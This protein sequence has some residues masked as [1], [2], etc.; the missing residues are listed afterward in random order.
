MFSIDVNGAGM[1]A[2]SASPTSIDFGSQA[3]SASSGAHRVTVTNTGPAPLTI[4]SMSLAGTNAREFSLRNST[5][6]GTIAAGGSCAADAVFTPAVAGARVATITLQSNASNGA[7]S[8]ALR[9]SGVVV[10]APP[11]SPWASQDVGAVGVAGSVAYSGGTFTVRGSGADIWGSADAFRF[12]HQALTGDGTIVARVAAVDNVQAWTKA[13]VMIRDGAAAGAPNAAMIVSAGKGLSFQYRRTSGGITANVAAAGVAPQWVRLTRAGNIF[14]AAISSDGAAW[15]PAGQATIA[16]S[17]TVRIGLAVTSHSATQAAAGTFDHVSIAAASATSALPGGW[18]TTD[19]GASG[20]SGS[21]SEAGGTFTVAG[22]G[23]DIWGT[24]DAFRYAYGTLAAD[25]AI[26]ARVATVQSI[27]TW[28][29]AGVMIRQSLAA[30][31]A[32]ASIFVT[33]AKGIA[34]QRRAA[35]G[36]TTVSTTIAGAPPAYVKLTRAGNLVTASTSADG[37]VWKTV[38]QQTMS[39]SGAMWVGVAVS[40]HDVTQRATATFDRVTVN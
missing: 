5:C 39:F 32:H 13:G 10:S 16:M 28:T 29:K 15:T 3:V 17:S 4:Y 7:L 18:Q 30:G 11:P 14:T 22:A 27:N 25:G 19:I 6:A 31:S 9:G 24:A 21:A 2:A 12:A 38:G 37:V 8:V 33:P 40:S 34:F 36:G 35:S 26:V 1:P 23:A 20:K